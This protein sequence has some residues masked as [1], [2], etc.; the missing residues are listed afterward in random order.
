LQEAPQYKPKFTGQ[1]GVLKA[2]TASAVSPIL[3]KILTTLGIIYS[4]AEHTLMGSS[5][6]GH[7]AL[8]SVADKLTARMYNE[9][10]QI[11]PLLIDVGSKFR[12]FNNLCN[13]KE[14]TNDIS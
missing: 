12:V 1:N 6:G 9:I 5:S 10:K 3:A 8:R 11:P 4:A 2:Q 13:L 7:D 14:W